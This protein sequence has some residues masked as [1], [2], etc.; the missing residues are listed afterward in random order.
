MIHLP[1]IA[2]M[3]IALC[4]LSAALAFYDSI[5]L[6]SGR[7][8]GQQLVVASASFT[9]DGK[10]LVKPDGTIPMQVM[11]TKSSMREII[12][13]LDIRSETFSWLYSLTWDWGKRPIRLKAVNKFAKDHCPYSCS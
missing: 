2:G 8:S 13:E 5:V 9:H 7:L 4:L 3:C 12:R 6:K 10:I 11:G 1:A